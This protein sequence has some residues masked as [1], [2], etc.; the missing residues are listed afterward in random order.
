MKYRS[1]S[2]IPEHNLI[3]V[4]IVGFCGLS[5]FPCKLKLLEDTQWR[6]RPHA[7]AMHVLACTLLHVSGKS[8]L[9]KNVNMLSALAQVMPDLLAPFFTD[10]SGDGRWGIN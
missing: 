6:Q 2:R 5:F 8:R 1:Q 9:F 4:R 7:I 10:F 3:T